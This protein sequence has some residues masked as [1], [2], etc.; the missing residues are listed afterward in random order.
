[1][2]KTNNNT[3]TTKELYPPLAYIIIEKNNSTQELKQSISTTADGT[4]PPQS[5][6]LRRPCGALQLV[7]PVTLHVF[8]CHFGVN[9]APPVV[10][11]AHSAKNL[12]NRNEATRAFS[13]S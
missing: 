13:R 5:P 9:S 4:P 8:R 11:T 1:M 10:A 7:E 12:A 6:T 3:P 2:E